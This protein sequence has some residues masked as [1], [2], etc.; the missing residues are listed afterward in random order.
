MDEKIERATTAYND[1]VKRMNEAVDKLGELA[2]D[3]DADTL[4]PIQAEFDEAEK[5]VERCKAEV[6]RLERIKK[7]RDDNP[8]ADVITANVD[9]TD[10]KRDRATVGKEEGVYRPD[11]EFSFF[12]DGL[13]AKAGDRDAQDR[14]YRN[15]QHARDNL[16]LRPGESRVVISTGGTGG[17]FIPPIY[18]GE[19]WAELPRPARPFADQIPTMAM[20]PDGLVITVPKVSTGVTVANQTA[21]NVAVSSTDIATTTVTATMATIAGQQDISRQAIERSFPGLDMVIFRDL[22][23]AYDGQL[24]SQLLNGTGANGQ[25]LGVRN[26]SGAL[27]EAYT[28]NSPTQGELLPKLYEANAK[29]FNGRFLPADLMVMSPSRAAWLAAGL[30]S[31]FPLFQQGSLYQAVGPQA[32]GYAGNLA[33]LDIIRDPN[34]IA[35]AGAGTNQDEIYVVRTADYLLA[36]DPIRQVTFEE[37]L[38]AN[39]VIRLQLFAYSF[40]VPHR[41]AQS[42]CIV[43]GTGLIPAAF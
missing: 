17:G 23:H 9:D 30:S 36:E 12:K 43:G 21:D 11:G 5:D 38:S 22:L 15:N 13:R 10:G 7:A 24:D 31:T 26:V 4:D 2:D 28:D 19:E 18:L 1:A 42:T 40:F 6:G 20:P 33:G 41:W 39:L 29:V 16:K 8:V 3:A 25:H 27:T 37:V 35:T 32:K 14:L 34:V